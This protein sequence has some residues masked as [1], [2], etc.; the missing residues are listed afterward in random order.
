MVHEQLFSLFS[1]LAYVRGSMLYGGA[2]PDDHTARLIDIAERTLSDEKGSNKGLRARTTFALIEAYQ[3]IV[4]H[5]TNTAGKRGLIA[6]VHDDRHT[7]VMTAN[8]VR[9]G[10][11]PGLLRALK[12]IDGLG[13]DELKRL[14]MEKLTT[15][16]TSARGGAGLG[17]I[18][19]AR[20]SGNALR[21]RTLPAGE[22][23]HR[24]QLIISCAAQDELHGPDRFAEL[25]EA[26]H[27]V[28]LLAGIGGT[29][30]S[31]DV[32]QHVLRIIEHE[33]D[34]QGTDLSRACL[35]T[36][37]M[38]HDLR[39]PN[40]PSLLLCRTDEQGC[41]I[42]MLTATDTTRSE[43]VLALTSRLNDASFADR[44]RAYHDALLGRVDKQ[45]AW[46]T[47][48]QDLAMRARSLEAVGRTLPEGAH[49]LLVEA[50]I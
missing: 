17:L 23:M 10:D 27:A 45:E 13:V 18:E 11:L 50:R 42:D 9:D 28:G 12:R 3:N 2:F 24:F 15:G 30:W 41:S 36:L 25:D 4:R 14:F 38:L 46:R 22:G 6:L 39:P 31:S 32:E 37:Q 35:A 26:C 20:R 29:V 40:G 48:L 44:R 7:E 47:G 21:H 43:K 16:T 5:R 1:S 8:D 33:P 19:M 49:V 34:V